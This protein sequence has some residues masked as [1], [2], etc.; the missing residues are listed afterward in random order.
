MS[1]FKTVSFAEFF[2]EI[3]VTYGRVTKRVRT[4]PA[5]RDVVQ[6]MI[7][8]A[9]SERLIAFIGFGSLGSVSDA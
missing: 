2:L 1:R 4:A 8:G 9:L 3:E 7:T 5:R 6:V